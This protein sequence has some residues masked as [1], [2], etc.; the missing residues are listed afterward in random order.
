MIG[1]AAAEKRDDQVRAGQAGAPATRRL[2]P[3]VRALVARTKYEA[4]KVVSFPM[5]GLN[6]TAIT[7]A[8]NL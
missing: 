2:S 6:V 4:P 3:G 5:D 8:G 1:T 7:M